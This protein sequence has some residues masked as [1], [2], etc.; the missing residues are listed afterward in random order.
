[1]EMVTGPNNVFAHRL[2]DFLPGGDIGG[3]RNYSRADVAHLQEVLGHLRPEFDRLNRSAWLTETQQRLAA[4]APYA[5]AD[6]SV[7]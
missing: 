6:G 1:M 5:Q 2:L 7:F 3:T 4:I